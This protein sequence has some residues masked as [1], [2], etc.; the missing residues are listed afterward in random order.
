MERNHSAAAGWCVW[1]SS[2]NGLGH[3]IHVFTAFCMPRKKCLHKASQKC[4]PETS[5]IAQVG[6]EGTSGGE[7][8]GKKQ[9][10]KTASIYLLF[11]DC[12]K[13][14]EAL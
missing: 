13:L 12:W 5:E 11:W 4:E 9:N 8:I 1:R 6:G 14:F 7:G 2:R 3:G 10:T